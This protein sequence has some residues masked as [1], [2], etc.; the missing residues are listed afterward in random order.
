MATQGGLVSE[1]FKQRVR[2]PEHV[3]VRALQGESVIL[4][5]LDEQYVGLDRVG[6]RFWETLA[7]AAS[8]EQA[9][10][11]LLAEYEVDPVRLESDI[12]GFIDGLVERN[13]IEL[14]DA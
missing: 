10:A 9:F 14:L 1:L 5:L 7:A 4:N 11:V 13:L 3:L 12:A 2:V 8:I 6:T